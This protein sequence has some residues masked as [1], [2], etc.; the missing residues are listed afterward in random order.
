MANITEKFRVKTFQ[1]AETWTLPPTLSQAQV[2]LERKNFFA[3]T[4]SSEDVKDICFIKNELKAA[5]DVQHHDAKALAK[6]ASEN[7]MSKLKRTGL[8]LEDKGEPSCRMNL[9]EVESTEEYIDSD[10]DYGHVQNLLSVDTSVPFEW[11]SKRSVGLFA[12]VRRVFFGTL[13]NDNHPEANYLEPPFMGDFGNPP[14]DILNTQGISGQMS[15]LL[16]LQS[17]HI[18]AL[19]TW[20]MDYIQRVDHLLSF[21]LTDRLRTGYFNWHKEQY[22]KAEAAR[23]QAEEEARILKEKEERAA[24]VAA[25]EARKQKEKEMQEVRGVINVMGGWKP[26]QIATMISF[27]SSK[28]K[29]T[30]EVAV[31]ANVN[32]ASSSSSSTKEPSAREITQAKVDKALKEQEAKRIAKE[33]EEEAKAKA[34][35]AEEEASDNGTTTTT[36]TNE[37]TGAINKAALIKQ[38]NV[39]LKNRGMAPYIPTGGSSSSNNAGTTTTTINE[40]EKAVQA[41]SFAQNVT[42]GPTGGSSSSENVENAGTTTTTTIREKGKAPRQLGE[43]AQQTSTVLNGANGSTTKEEKETTKANPVEQK[44]MPN[45]MMAKLH[46]FFH[47]DGEKDKGLRGLVPNVE[48]VYYYMDGVNSLEKKVWMEMHVQLNIL[49]YPFDLFGAEDHMMQQI[50]DENGKACRRAFEGLC[51]D[52]DDLTKE[53]FNTLEKKLCD[54]TDKK[55]VHV[56]DSSEDDSS[57]DDDDD[58]EANNGKSSSSSDDDENEEENEENKEVTDLTKSFS[59]A[60]TIDE[61]NDD[62]ALKQYLQTPEGKALCVFGYRKKKKESNNPNIFNK[63]RSTENKKI[64]FDDIA[65]LELTEDFIK[66]YV[67]NFARYIHDYDCDR[68]YALGSL[69][70][71][72]EKEFDKLDPSQQRALPEKAGTLWRVTEYRSDGTYEIIAEYNT[73]QEVIADEEDLRLPVVYILGGKQA[74]KQARKRQHDDD[75]GASSST[76]ASSSRDTRSQKKRKRKQANIPNVTHDDVNLNT[77]RLQ[78]EAKTP[79]KLSGFNA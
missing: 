35:K 33:K 79:T 34:K 18:H 8:V 47:G 25:E 62:D 11:D 40:K 7:L 23:K 73:T 55:Y 52:R 64:P 14:E 41:V 24:R 48:D 67:I 28:A 42:G 63:V 51:P 49:S 70:M 32:G 22:E 2:V 26:D 74:R 76:G 46:T 78:K 68:T 37:A 72:T 60:S 50:E 58:D 59:I 16:Y 4:S 36:N 21:V 54:A 29:M 10:V 17:K 45:E 66:T 39:C 31:N 77:P 30:A 9:L 43:N 1:G 69:V 20:R 3:I 61:L 5:F 56:P 13:L 27:L 19:H 6:A 44:K 65:D 75:A 12:T 15:D 57:D 53:D 71:L 38:L